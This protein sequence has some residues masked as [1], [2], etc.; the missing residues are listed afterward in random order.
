M[1]LF[2]RLKIMKLIKA[3]KNKKKNKNKRT[4]HKRMSLKVAT[5]W[6]YNFI[7]SWQRYLDASTTHYCLLENGGVSHFCQPLPILSFNLFTWTT[8]R[9]PTKVHCHLLLAR[10]TSADTVL[11]M[12]MWLPARIVEQMNSHF[13]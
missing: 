4:F 3:N 12:T 5:K 1:V 6:H 11:Q 13:N 8:R 7:S 2:A 10:Q 9:W